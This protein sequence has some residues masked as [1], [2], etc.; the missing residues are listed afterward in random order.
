M[1]S[2]YL[3]AVRDKR[4]G[5]ILA[6]K[7]SAR[8]IPSTASA[9]PTGAGGGDGAPSATSNGVAG[10]ASS[11]TDTSESTPPCNESV[12]ESRESLGQLGESLPLWSAVDVDAPSVSVTPGDRGDETPHV[13]LRPC[14]VHRVSPPLPNSPRLSTARSIEASVDV[15]V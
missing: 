9:T 4:S 7:P 2:A 12:G 13:H 8:I 10:R 11:D 3:R 1:R 6:P 15:V 5:S 14:V